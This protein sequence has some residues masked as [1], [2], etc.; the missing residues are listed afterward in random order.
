MGC[1]LA[2]SLSPESFR[3]LCKPLRLFYLAE[4]SQT[5][6]REWS[7][8]RI[9]RGM[10]GCGREVSGIWFCYTSSVAGAQNHGHGLLWGDIWVCNTHV[11]EGI[12]PGKDR[13]SRLQPQMGGS[14]PEQTR[15]VCQGD[16]SVPK[17]LWAGAWTC[18]QGR[19]K[20][21][22]NVDRATTFHQQGEMRN[23]KRLWKSKQWKHFFWNLHFWLRFSMWGS[24]E[25]RFGE[26]VPVQG[27]VQSTGTAQSWQQPRV[28]E[29]CVAWL[30][31]WG[32]SSLLSWLR[33]LVCPQGKWRK[34][35]DIF[36]FSFDGNAKLTVE[37]HVNSKVG[38]RSQSSKW[39]SVLEA[40]SWIWEMLNVWGSLE[41]GRS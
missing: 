11:G 21:S 15:D 23:I 38:S 37:V 10:E 34:G 24:R 31:M 28:T 16:N 2:C 20:T 36:T 14:S 5:S 35:R 33:K 29:L 26:L 32:V 30:C 12:T 7:E 22:A 40:K 39:L 18:Q 13:A 1:V 19:W 17:W 3:V 27:T 4:L 25:P 41:P 8:S 9:R 6:V